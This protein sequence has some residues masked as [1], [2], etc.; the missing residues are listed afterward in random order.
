MNTRFAEISMSVYAIILAGGTGS[1]T[2]NAIPKQFIPI[3]G[4]PLICHTIDRF[5]QNYGVNEIIIVSHPDYIPTMT[6]LVSES[7]FHKVTH[8]V[9]GSETRQGSSWNGLVA[10]KGSQGDIILIHDAARPFVSD[11]IITDVI[12][13]A[14]EHGA[15]LP[16]IPPADTIFEHVDGRI[17]GNVLD[18]NTLMCAQTPQ[19]FEFK[20]IMNA[21]EKAIED[22]LENAT[23]D[24]GLVMRTGIDCAIVRGDVDNI[25]ITTALDF[26]IAE[27]IM[28]SLKP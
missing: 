26:I 3:C 7:S 11:R 10:C 24:T 5:E 23:D 20:I 13:S 21:H 12:I 9:Q 17:I 14:G 22:K 8:I 27:A 19:G 28:K 1:R 18:R 2:G 15:S 25:K 16:S 4:K 6:D